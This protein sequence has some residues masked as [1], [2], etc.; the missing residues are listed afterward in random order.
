MSIYII[1]LCVRLLRLS[2]I[3]EEVSE[4]EEENVSGGEEPDIEEYESDS[5]SGYTL[6]KTRTLLY[7]CYS[8]HLVRFE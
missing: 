3:E 4:R 2:L 6:V 1:N 7:A 8:V 5:E